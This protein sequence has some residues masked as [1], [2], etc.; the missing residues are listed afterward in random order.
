MSSYLCN[1]FQSLYFF[2]FNFVKKLIQNFIFNLN[3]FLS[4]LL[5][6]Y[7]GGNI[8]DASACLLVCA[9]W[10]TADSGDSACPL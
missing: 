9:P 2:T 5:F 8:I 7:L 4:V 3:I 6:S 1:T 10:G